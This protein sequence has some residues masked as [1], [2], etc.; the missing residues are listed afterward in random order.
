MC[1]DYSIIYTE[2][3]TMASSLFLSNY[4]AYRRPIPNGKGSKTERESDLKNK[5][6]GGH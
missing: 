5:Q 1:I 6:L 3:P 4:Q 2:P